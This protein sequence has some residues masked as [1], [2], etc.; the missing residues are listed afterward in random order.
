MEKKRQ[1]KGGR[2]TTDIA[3]RDVAAID[4]PSTLAMRNAAPHE[5]DG[6]GRPLLQLIQDT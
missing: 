4:D 6:S 2:E 1:M 5:M 3:S